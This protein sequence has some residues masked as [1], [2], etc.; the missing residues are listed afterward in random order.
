MARKTAR[1]ALSIVG[2]AI[3][4]AVAA[5]LNELFIYLGYLSLQA[6]LQRWAYISVYVASGLFTGIMT[7][8][9][10]PRLI[11]GFIIGIR[12]LEAK[13]TDMPL[14][15]IF[16]GAVGLIIGLLLAL[17]LST[18]TNSIPLN[19]VVAVVNIF[20][21]VVFGYLGCSIAIKRRNEINMPGWFKRGRDKAH[22]SAD[23]AAPKVLDTS[24]IIDGRIFDIC[25]TGIIEGA[26]I[27]PGFVL[28]ELRHIADSADSLKRNRGRR[29]LDILNRMQEELEMPIRVDDKDYEE[30]SEVDAKLIRLTYELGGVVVTN[31]YNLNKVAGV[32]RVPVFNINELANAV[33]SV[34]LP[35]EELNA[36]I[37][38]E[39][40]E[41]GQGIAYLEDGTMIVVDGGRHFVG[42]DKM[43]VVTSVLQTA[44]GRMIFAKL[45]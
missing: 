8:I 13:L 41:P 34:V 19:W 5:G 20:L 4:P 1:V 18:L 15:D 27:I 6:V 39:G 32:Q 45:K 11:D 42:D 35:G 44:A 31:D 16:F 7:F 22:R 29:G 38:K 36:A 12:A 21:Y 23:A 3:G 10:S 33:K 25:K 30:L 28:Q 37:V 9:F 40:K 14:S 17:L 2:I 43:V 26:L 24:V